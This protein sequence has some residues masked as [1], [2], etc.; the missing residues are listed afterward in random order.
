MILGVLAGIE[1]HVS[2]EELFDAVR[3]V[4]PSIGF[5]TVHR[6]LRLL[7]DSGFVH[8]H[9]FG[10]RHRR[11]ELADRREHHDHLICTRCRRIVEFEEPRIEALQDEVAARHGFRITDHR[12]DLFGICVTCMAAETR[13][14]RRDR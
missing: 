7:A 10:E 14:R 11:Y 1:G 13:P 8:E 5:A 3:K 12:L 9:S 4:E 2:A 6:T